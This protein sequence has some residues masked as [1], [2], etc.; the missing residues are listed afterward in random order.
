MREGVWFTTIGTS[1]HAISNG[2]L[3]AYLAG[4]WCPTHVVCFSLMPPEDLVDERVKMNL[5][6]SFDA[7][8]SWLK[9]FKEVLNRDVELIPIS[10]DEDN[11]EGYR[12]DLRGMLE[13]YHDKPKAMDITPGRKFASAIMMQEGIRAGA[14]AIF[15]LHLLDEAYQQQPLL[16]IPAVYQRLVDLKREVQ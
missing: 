16:N 15:Y 13:H 9:R 3:A 5:D 8:K 2:I 4:E 7:F 1:P 14:D 11:Y 12:K 6:N 10:C